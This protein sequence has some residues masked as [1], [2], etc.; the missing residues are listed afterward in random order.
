MP[1]T[2]DDL[3]RIPCILPD[4]PIS[5]AGW[6]FRDPQSD[7]IIEVPLRPRLIATAEASMEA[8]VRGVGLV[9]L[10]HYQAEQA[11]RAGKL[12]IVLADYELE[13]FPVHLVHAPRAQM[14]LKMRRFLD[15]AAPRLRQ[16][17]AA[18]GKA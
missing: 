6:R 13:P 8:A 12:Q 9:R 2:P 11:L 15:F 3:E 17:I 7:A 16:A 14:P 1:Q 10:L 18:I 5:T 4:G